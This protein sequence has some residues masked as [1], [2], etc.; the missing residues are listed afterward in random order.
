MPIWLAALSLPGSV[1][2]YKQQLLL[3]AAVM[4][5]VGCTAPRANPPGGAWF[6]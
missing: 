1:D 6:R 5:F 4:A 2:M 3:V